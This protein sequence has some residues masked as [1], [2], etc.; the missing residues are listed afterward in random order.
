MDKNFIFLPKWWNFAKSGHTDFNPLKDKIKH[1]VTHNEFLQIGLLN[2]TPFYGP[3][4]QEEIPT[5]LTVTLFLKQKARLCDKI[6]TLKV[7]E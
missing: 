7:G 2:Y 5:G 6:N 3:L 1:D 4:D